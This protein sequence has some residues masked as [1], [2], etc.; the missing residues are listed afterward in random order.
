VKD[1][2]FHATCLTTT[3]FYG[4]LYV[5]SAEATCTTLVLVLSEAPTTLWATDRRRHGTPDKSEW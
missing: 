4:Q 5:L 2:Q 1:I 3:Y